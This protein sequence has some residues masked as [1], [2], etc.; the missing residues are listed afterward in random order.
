MEGDEDID[1]AAGWE[2]LTGS[3]KVRCDNLVGFRPAPCE[4]HKFTG[5]QFVIQ[6]LLRAGAATATRPVL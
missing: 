6:H 1:F 4:S 3:E 2:K 5:L